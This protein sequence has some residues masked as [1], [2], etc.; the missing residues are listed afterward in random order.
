M[1]APGLLFQLKIPSRSIY[2]RSIAFFS[3][4]LAPN[5]RFSSF[6][7]EDGDD[8]D[9]STVYKRVLKF[10]RPTTI[11]YDGSFVN[12]VSL[13][14]T[15]LRPLQVI[16]LKDGPSGVYTLLGVNTDTLS[17]HSFRSVLFHSCL[18]LK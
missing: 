10:Q 7:S 2:L 15:V 14:G 3:S 18:L 11:K 6:P 5:A 8:E 9:G 4:S 1:K 17:N 16:R 13:I 12:S